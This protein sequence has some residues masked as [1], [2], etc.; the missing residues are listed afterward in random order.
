MRSTCSRMGPKFN[1]QLLEKKGKET[2]RAEGHVKMEA[3]IRAM[4]L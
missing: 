3:E 4:H 1:D 2:Y